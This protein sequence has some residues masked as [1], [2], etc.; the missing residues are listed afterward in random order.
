MI[1]QH[2]KWKTYQEAPIKG[3][4]FRK[5][6]KTRFRFVDY[7]FVMTYR[8][9]GNTGNFILQ[10][11]VFRGM[12]VHNFEKEQTIWR[13]FI[14]LI[15]MFLLR[16]QAGVE[17]V[18]RG[19]GVRDQVATTDENGLFTF[20]VKE[21][22]LEEGWNELEVHLDEIMV[23]GQEP[24]HA[25]AQIMIRDEFEYGVISD[26]DDTLL[27]SHITQPLK[28]FFLLMTKNA[29]S[30]KPVEGVVRFY[31][32]L[33]QREEKPINPFFYVSSSE[34]NLYDFLNRFMEHNDFPK[35]VLQLKELKD[36]WTDFFR[37]GYG[38]HDHKRLKIER[39]LQ[40]FP[41]REFILVG[42]NG[43]QDAQIYLDIA[44]EY[45]DQVKAIYIRQATS[46]H[47][48]KVDALLAEIDELD[49]PSLQYKY[50]TD[51]VKHAE[52]HEII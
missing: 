36:S 43:Q 35:G 20:E 41:G 31:Q 51:A 19:D 13:N 9:Y 48:A 29:F 2:P 15:K 10:G 40:H 1:S 50:V 49:I 46:S 7:P 21:H 45:N 22:Q 5:W 42:D 33:A 24:V 11:H 39:I 28:K 25:K 14:Y 32:A 3:N 27:I 47:T 26:I 52:K 38:S 4:A 37:S 8:G 18:L 34:W 30:R 12:A 17:V 44:R 16:T 6:L 23:E